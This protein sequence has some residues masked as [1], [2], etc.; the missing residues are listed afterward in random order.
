MLITLDYMMSHILIV[1]VQV[2]D[3]IKT[4]KGNKSGRERQQKECDEWDGFLYIKIYINS[5]QPFL[6]LYLSCKA[7][8][9]VIKLH[10]KGRFVLWTLFILEVHINLK[11]DDNNQK[12]RF[13]YHY[14]PNIHYS[15]RYKLNQSG[16]NV[17]SNFKFL[18]Y[19]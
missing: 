13:H 4:Q 12:I 18:K 1:W 11:R 8:W 9:F 14:K 5:D 10:K 19:T 3:K 2:D 6:F 16:V 7:N 15:F 17:I